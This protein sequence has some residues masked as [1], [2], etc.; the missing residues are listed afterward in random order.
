MFVDKVCQ[1]KLK[2]SEIKIEVILN[3]EWLLL[4]FRFD[5]LFVLYSFFLFLILRLLL[6][7]FLLRCFLLLFLRSS[8]IIIEEVKFELILFRLLF[9][10]LLW[11]LA[12]LF[13]LF[14]LFLFLLCYLWFLINLFGLFLMSVLTLHLQRCRLVR[15]RVDWQLVIDLFISV[16]IVPIHTHPLQPCILLAHRLRDLKLLKLL[17]II[18]LHLLDLSLRLFTQR[19]RWRPTN[20][21]LRYRVLT[22]LL[23]LATVVRWWPLACV[24]RCWLLLMLLGV[25][26]VVGRIWLLLTLH[27][28]WQVRRRVPL[29]RFNIK[30]H[31]HV[32]LL[33][34]HI[35]Q[36]AL[37]LNNIFQILSFHLPQQ[38]IMFGVVVNLLYIRFH[39][40]RTIQ[41]YNMFLELVS[42]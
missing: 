37:P 25:W 19:H 6:L 13:W 12:A 14:S 36:I 8:A 9:L 26:V 21:Y 2:I 27:I 39:T 35:T 1:W 32:A 23:M 18:L 30:R 4:N 10:F 11:L 7:R 33:C 17:I 20:A 3:S 40:F 38:H 15:V 5:L 29:V 28:R 34:F 41:R 22:L 31:M 24:R 42:R 16:D